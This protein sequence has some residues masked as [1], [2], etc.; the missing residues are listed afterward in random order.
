M[1]HVNFKTIFLAVNCTILAYGT[2]ISLIHAANGH[3]LKTYETLHAKVW[4]Q[5]DD[6]GDD[7][8]TGGGTTG[9]GTTGGD[10]TGGNTDPDNPF[11]LKGYK[12]VYEKESMPV[13]SD[14]NGN[15]STPLGIQPG[16][17]PDTRY[18][19]T[20]KIWYCGM[21]DDLNDKCDPMKE[22][23]GISSIKPV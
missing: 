23:Q 12:M 11:I 17:K 3:G 16:F 19:V 6:S 5:L 20:I 7:T 21:S 13:T 9:D 22:G 4:A 18:T 10:D 1:K 8:G 2:I 14:S 15:V